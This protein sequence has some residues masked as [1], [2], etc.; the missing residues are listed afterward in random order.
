M[1][2]KKTRR[3]ALLM[4]LTMLIGALGVLPIA[5]SAAETD[6]ADVSAT[7]LPTGIKPYSQYT[8]DEKNVSALAGSGTESDPYLISNAAEFEFFRAQ[9]RGATA[10]I[11]AVYRLT[12]D[13]V[14]N[15]DIN[16]NDAHYNLGGLWNANVSFGGTLDGDGHT[17][18]N[19]YSNMANDVPALFHHLSAEA[20]IKNLNFNGVY[21]ASAKNAA[22]KGGAAAILAHGDCNAKI[23]NVHAKNVTLSAYTVGGFVAGKLLQSGQI[24][25]CSAENLSIEGYT[26]GGIVNSATGNA[27]I[28]NCRTSGTISGSYFIGGIAGHNT[29][30]NVANA[31]YIRNCTNNATIVATTSGAGILGAAQDANGSYNCRFEISDCVNNGAVTTQKYAGGIVGTSY[32]TQGQIKLIRCTNNGAVTAE[33]NTA[34]MAGGMISRIDS[35]TSTSTTMITDCINYGAITSNVDAGGLLGQC[36]A[37]AVGIRFTNS[38]NF[39]AVS[40]TANVGGFIGFFNNGTAAIL[41]NSANYGNVGSLSATKNAGGF[42][43]SITTTDVGVAIN[44]GLMMANVSGSSIAGAIAGYVGGSDG[45]ANKLELNNLWVQGTMTSKTQP[46]TYGQG[47][48]LAA[49]A[50]YGN[51]AIALLKNGV[52]Q[53][54]SSSA[55]IVDASAFTDGTVQTSLNTYVTNKN[56]ALGDLDAH[57]P[58]V[59]NKVSAPTFLTT[60]G[61]SGA[62]MSL[63]GNMALNMKL[64]ASILAHLDLMKVTFV[65]ADTNMGVDTVIDDNGYYTAAYDKRAADMAESMN[66]C[67]VVTLENGTS[68]RSTKILSYSPVEYL[69]HLYEDYTGAKKDEDN[70]A[71]VLDVVV[72]MLA[73]GAEAE[74]KMKSVAFE[75]TETAKAAE[76]ANITLPTTFPYTN[77]E[78]APG[79]MTGEDTAAINSV[80][81]TGA[82]LTGGISITFKM[83]NAAYTKLTV[84]DVAV[85]DVRDGYIIFE[86]ILPIN[87]LASFQLV[88]SGEGVEDVTANFC[89]GD[90]LEMRRANAE[91]TALVEATVRYMMAVREYALNMQ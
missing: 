45:K 69:T 36:T 46:I 84:S 15:T 33:T 28:E 32:M 85:Y 67:L 8:E 86:N 41:H 25:N 88:F 39:G 35:L 14:F 27:V 49:T 79:R 17:I 90:F 29:N 52:E 13:I 6:V 53:T 16:I 34:A 82:S 72:N 76:A 51:F 2:G 38:A 50:N 22:T 59:K 44:N 18:Y 77:N 89:V 21:F 78:H 20:T 19:M 83:K 74:A 71:S 10:K 55:N 87:I 12:N 7:V 63:G 31:L 24:V 57:A 75:A 80:A 5:A 3:I 56:A 73:Y 40:G 9:V 54:V 91:E 42:F 81:E 30:D 61:F 26:A 66:L 60:L 1:Y 68:Y 65:D 11:T 23:E 43:G 4:T 62:T 48:S 58:W 64:D 47:F 37:K 70:A